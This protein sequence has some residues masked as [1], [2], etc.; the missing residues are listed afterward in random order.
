MSAAEYVEH[1]R[2][3]EIYDPTLTFQMEN[4]FELLGVL[5]DYMHDDA[6][7]GWSVLIVWHN[8]DYGRDDDRT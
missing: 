1:V 7:D 2:A 5:E 6:T 8:P 4:G 3:G